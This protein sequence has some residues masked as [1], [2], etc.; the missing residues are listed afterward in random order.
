MRYTGLPFTPLANT[1]GWIFLKKNQKMGLGST[2]IFDHQCLR[3]IWITIWI[4]KKLSGFFRLLIMM[5]L[6]GDMHSMSALI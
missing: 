4:H 2:Q 1:I 6:G 3:V 5:C